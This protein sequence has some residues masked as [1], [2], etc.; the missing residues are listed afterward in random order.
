[1]QHYAVQYVNYVVGN[2]H[3]KAQLYWGDAEQVELPD[4]IFV[5]CIML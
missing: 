4:K 2:E 3:K 5:L 1:M